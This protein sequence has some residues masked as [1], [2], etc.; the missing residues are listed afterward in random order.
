MLWMVLVQ[1]LFRLSQL[2][3]GTGNGKRDALPASIRRWI[4]MGLGISRA[5]ATR[6]EIDGSVDALGSDEGSPVDRSDPR[7][8]T[9]PS[10]VSWQ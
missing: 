4:T 7:S 9:G 8:A 1:M 3:S 6:E 5:S 10:R 2:V